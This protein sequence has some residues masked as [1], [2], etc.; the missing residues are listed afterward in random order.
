MCGLFIFRK[1]RVDAVEPPEGGTENGSYIVRSSFA[2]RICHELASALQFSRMKA[3]D[4]VRRLRRR[5]A[6]VCNQYLCQ[7]FPSR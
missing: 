2:A 1:W 3:Y 5:V 6:Q 7:G 4:E